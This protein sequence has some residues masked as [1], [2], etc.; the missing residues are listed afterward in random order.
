[1]VKEY[2][3]LVRDDIPEIIRKDG[4]TPVITVATGPEY[5]EM[6]RQKL[7]EEVQEYQ[8]SQ[9]PEE[10]ADIL[11]VVYALAETEGTTKSDIEALRKSKRKD[12]GGFGDGIILLE[13]RD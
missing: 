13:V 6:L 10:L 2:D 7:D 1:M 8:D 11:E 12:R 5:N 3:K 4:K 9:D